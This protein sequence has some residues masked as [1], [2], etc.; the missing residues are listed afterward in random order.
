MG[1]VARMAWKRNDWRVLVGKF[2]GKRQLRRPRGIW[3]HNIKMEHNEIGMWPGILGLR[4][5]T[6]RGLL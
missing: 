5:G 4:V 3:Q 6:V 2:E 1:R